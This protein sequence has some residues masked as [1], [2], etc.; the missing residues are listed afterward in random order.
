MSFLASLLLPV[1]ATVLFFRSY[2]E[3]VALGKAPALLTTRSA[4]VSGA[5][6]GASALIFLGLLGVLILAHRGR[7]LT[8]EGVEDSAIAFWTVQFILAAAIGAVIG[9]LSALALLPWVR[10]RLARSA[11]PREIQ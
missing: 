2:P 4:L 11:P 1:L 6:T 3:R 10:S 7:A 8:P 9:A 5:V